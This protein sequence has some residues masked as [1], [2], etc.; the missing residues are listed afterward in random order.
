MAPVLKKEWLYALTNIK[1]YEIEE[2]HV[3]Q[4]QI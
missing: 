3:I 4:F 2:N 1:S